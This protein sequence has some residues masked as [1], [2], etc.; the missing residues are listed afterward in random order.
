MN[1]LTLRKSPV[2]RIMTK[3]LSKVIPDRTKRLVMLSSLYANLC[4]KTNFNSNTI[5][6][7]NKIMALSSDDKA[8]EFPMHI[9]SAIWHGD[10]GRTIL[11]DSSSQQL[12]VHDLIEKIISTMPQWLVYSD[13]E[14]VSQDIAKLLANRSKLEV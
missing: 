3:V 1:Q 7:L 14:I 4:N 11:H 6:K 10:H 12:S 2:S 5:S 9:S 13:K 8:L